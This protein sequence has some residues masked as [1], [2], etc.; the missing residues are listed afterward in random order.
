MADD[1]KPQIAELAN[2]LSTFADACARA[3]AAANRRNEFEHV[4]EARTPFLLLRVLGPCREPGPR[5]V[6]ADSWP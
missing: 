1:E 4:R 6:G 5:S 2:T 3:A